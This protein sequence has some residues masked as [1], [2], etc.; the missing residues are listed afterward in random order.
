MNWKT[1]IIGSLSLPLWCGCGLYTT[2]QRPETLPIEELYRTETT[3]EADS[4]SLASLSWRELFVDPLL[5]RWIEVGFNQNSD[6]RT[7]RLRTEEAQATL[8]ASKLAFLPALSLTPQGSLS[9]YDGASRPRVTTWGRVRSGR[10][11]LS[12]G[13]AT[14]SEEAKPHWRRAVPTSRRCRPS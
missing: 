12:A 7:A 13:C 4:V 2:Y 3:A 8:T 11:M 9:S 10:S 14:P 5:V 6:L 1:I